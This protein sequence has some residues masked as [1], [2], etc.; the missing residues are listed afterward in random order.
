MAHLQ[1]PVSDGVPELSVLHLA[2]GIVVPVIS[3]HTVVVDVD[4]YAAEAA[5]IN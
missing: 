3:K 4:R 2:V 1:A 5:P